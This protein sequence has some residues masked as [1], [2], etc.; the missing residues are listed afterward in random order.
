VHDSFYEIYSQKQRGESAL[1]HSA[2]NFISTECVQE[3]RNEIFSQKL[4]LELFFAED[5]Y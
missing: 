4:L 1:N 2:G 5:D 3:M